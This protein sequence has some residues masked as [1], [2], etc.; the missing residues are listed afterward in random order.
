MKELLIFINWLALIKSCLSKWAILRMTYSM[1]IAFVSCRWL[2]ASGGEQFPGGARQRLHQWQLHPGGQRVQGIYCLTGNFLYSCIQILA[3]LIDAFFGCGLGS[4][5]K[6]IVFSFSHIAPTHP[7]I[8]CV[9][10][11]LQ[12]LSQMTNFSPKHRARCPTPQ[13]TSGGWLWSAKSRSSLWPPTR[14]REGR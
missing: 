2:H 7:L 4:L 5:K 11:W 6:E 9:I 8:L 3:P 14:R 1:L 10:L 13:L 12:K